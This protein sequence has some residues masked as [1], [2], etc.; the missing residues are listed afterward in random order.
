MSQPTELQ[1]DAPSC[2]NCG[3]PMDLARTMPS[4]LPRE[5]GAKTQIYECG[6]CGATVARTVR[7]S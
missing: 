3:V 4:A 5:A 6:R 1:F 2:P 7:L